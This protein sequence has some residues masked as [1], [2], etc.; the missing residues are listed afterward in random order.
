VGDNL[1]L[2]TDMP[3]L[4]RAPGDYL[5]RV[6]ALDRADAPVGPQL[7]ALAKNYLQ[8]SRLDRL[9][10]RVE[11]L[12]SSGADL[13]PLERVHLG[14]V[15]NGTSDF[16]ANAL[17][18]TGLRYGL[19]LQLT[20]ADFDQSVQE[21]LDPQATVNAAK[22]DLI[23][24]AL[25]HRGLP[26]GPEGGAWGPDAAQSALDHLEMLRRS[27]AENSGATIMLQTIAR[28]PVSIF[29]NFDRRVAGTTID[30]VASFNGRLPKMLEGSADLLL[31]VASLA[32]TVGLS[33]WHDHVRWH[34]AKIPF[35]LDSLPLWA[36][37]VCRLIAAWR[38]RSRKVLVLDLD[39]TLWGG[40]IGDDGI[41][42][43]KIGQGDAVGEAHLA[44]QHVAKALSSRGI[45]LAVCSKNDDANARLPFRE[46]P[47]MILKENDFAAFVANWTDKAANL[48]AIAKALN[49]GL[50]SLVFLDDNPAERDQVR[51]ALPEV[52]VPEI[53]ADPSSYASIITSAG[54][55]EAVTFSEEDRQRAA[56]YQQNTARE[57]LQV[58]AGSIDDYLK[59]LNMVADIRAFDDMGRARITQLIN[60]TNQFNLT[61]L[62]ADEKD[63]LA[64]QHSSAHV[65]LQTR[66][67]DKF[68]DNGMISV[69]IAEKDSERWR[70]IQWLMSCRV[71]NRKVEEA[72]LNRLVIEAGASGVAVI[73]GVY[74]PTA[75]NSLVRDHYRK[76]GFEQAAS[77]EDGTTHWHLNVTTYKQRDVPMS[78]V[79]TGEAAA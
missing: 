33:T 35:A 11:V 8:Q 50:D 60:K 58:Q 56:Q 57:R 51:Q 6:A 79:D 4:L 7:V 21:A 2:L 32:E 10:K 44:L 38:G 42:G 45:V 19:D 15:T 30:A 5:A 1:V 14:L 37:H 63:V 55:F 20:V 76:L 65:T 3:W 28:P 23:L 78:L 13:A 74:R 69:V 9:G 54:Y 26:F 36:D 75:K 66:L 41:D 31:D 70:I 17:R 59:S 62:R 43:I 52:A 12:Q 71:L 47:D 67:V 18:A 61:T 24:L 77:G 68:G 48:R 72:V 49:L 64:W 40:V 16:L 34:V 39:N 46:H 25:D 53:P 22:P 73:E 27:F 29:G